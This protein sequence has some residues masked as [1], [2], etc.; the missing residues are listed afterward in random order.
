MYG[1][2]VN[3]LA[4]DYILPPN[5]AALTRLGSA[6]PD[7]WSVLPRKPLPL[8]VQRRLAASD[9]PRAGLLAIG[10]RSHLAADACFHGHQEFR[11]RMDWLSPKLAGAWP[12]LQHASFAAHVLVEMVLDSWIVAQRPHR[13][14]DYY[15]SFSDNGIVL[16][17]K[18]CAENPDMET[19]VSA[20]LRRFA[21]AQFL[22]DYDTAEGTTDRF[23]RLLAHTPFPTKSP[24]DIRD[25]VQVVREAAATFETGS[26][27]LLQD[28]RVASDAALA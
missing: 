14:D 2:P 20:I 10:I 27:E 17:S 13:L 18:L 21:T 24:R 15:A 22:R 25:V 11:R 7:L 26:L 19:D 28:V 1:T 16:A 5:S 4:H 6:L 23:V 8:V 12:G 3:F 9:D